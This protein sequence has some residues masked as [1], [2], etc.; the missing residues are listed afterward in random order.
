MTQLWK[1]SCVG[2]QEYVDTTLTGG[3]GDMLVSD[4]PAYIAPYLWRDPQLLGYTG[5]WANESLICPGEWDCGS[6]PQVLHNSRPGNSPPGSLFDIVQANYAHVYPQ[7]PDDRPD[8]LLPTGS[9]LLNKTTMEYVRGDIL[10]YGISLGHVVLMRICW[11]SHPDVGIQNGNYLSKG[12]WAGHRFEIIQE[13]MQLD[14]ETGW[15]DVGRG[16]LREITRLWETI[17]GED[18]RWRVNDGW[19]PE[20]GL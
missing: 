15:T 4:N 9:I 13:G 3:L 14:Q 12:A 7:Y 8:R 16:V 19:M 5:R 18:W 11:S 20:P 6:R 2:T 17:L 10:P 1:I